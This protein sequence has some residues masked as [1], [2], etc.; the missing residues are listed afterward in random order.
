MDLAKGSNYE[1]DGVENGKKEGT[2]VGLDNIEGATEGMNDSVGTDD[3]EVVDE[4]TYVEVAFGF[5]VVGKLGR[6]GHPG[7][8]TGRGCTEC[9]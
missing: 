2:V 6:S 3:K 4:N 1:E 9:A 7:W 8:C 5:C